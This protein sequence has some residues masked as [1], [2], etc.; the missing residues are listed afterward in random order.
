MES[1]DIFDCAVRVKEEPR[2]ESFIKNDYEMIDEKPDL[3]NFQLSP[4]PHETFIHTIKKCDIK[5]ES[6]LDNEVEIVVECADVKPNFDFLTIRKIGDDFQNS[7]GTV[8]NTIKKEPAEEVKQETVGDVAEQLNLNLDNELA[9]QSKKRRISKKSDHQHKIKTQIDTMHNGNIYTCETC[10]KTF[11]QKS[12]LKTH[13]DAMHNFTHSCDIC[14]KKLPTKKYL[15]MHIDT[16]HNGVKYVCEICKKKFPFKSN[17]QIHVNSVHYK[18]THTCDI[19]LKK[20][21]RKSYLKIH[22][23]S[24]HNGTKHACDI[25]G[26]S[27]TLKNGLKIHIDSVHNGITYSCDICGSTYKGKSSPTAKII[28]ALAD[29][30]REQPACQASWKAYVEWN[31]V[32]KTANVWNIKTV[33][34]EIRRLIASSTPHD[35]ARAYKLMLSEAQNSSVVVWRPPRN[36]TTTAELQRQVPCTIQCVDSKCIIVDESN[37]TIISNEEIMSGV[38][39][40]KRKECEQNS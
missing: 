6:E 27:F 29:R 25:C 23:D 17:L 39:T 22:I 11:T 7:L 24:A 3:R 12:Y 20:F 9:E 40:R 37:P 33:K 18:I 1:S 8:K 34:T 16:V 5:L 26:K 36:R 14:R 10:G 31:K 35:L 30:L 15:Q 32:E 4:F 2:D 19:C 13:I 38:K 21:T 28:R